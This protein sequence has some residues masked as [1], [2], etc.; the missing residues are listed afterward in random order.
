MENQPCEFC[1]RSLAALLQARAIMGDILREDDD[2]VL[3]SELIGDDEA[4]KKEATVLDQ[5]RAKVAKLESEAR[6]LLTARNAAKQEMNA[7]VDDGG[8]ASIVPA[9]DVGKAERP[10]S[11]DLLQ[12]LKSRGELRAPAE[13]ELDARQKF[14][15]SNYDYSTKCYELQSARE[16]LAQLEK[17]V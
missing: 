14:L 13:P 4:M 6:R 16:E 10:M 3:N 7:V 8:Y 1:Q 2:F 9:F 17:K 11:A 15:W 5:A 12:H